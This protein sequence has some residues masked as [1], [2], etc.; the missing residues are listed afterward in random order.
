MENS[1]KNTE[2]KVINP[3]GYKDTHGFLVSGK[4]VY[5][6]TE[7]ECRFFQL[8]YDR[9]MKEKEQQSSVVSQ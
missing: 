6:G 8:K 2:V 3:Q 5:I 7:H 9:K 4:V 1:L